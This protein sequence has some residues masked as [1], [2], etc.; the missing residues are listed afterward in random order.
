VHFVY[1]V[2][3]IIII[4]I[5]LSFGPSTDNTISFCLKSSQYLVTKKRHKQ[6]SESYDIPHNQAT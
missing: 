6:T 5:L 4:I 2:I 1:S 3:I